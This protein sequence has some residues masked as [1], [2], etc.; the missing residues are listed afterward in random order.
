MKNALTALA[1][2]LLAAAPATAAKK[3]SAKEFMERYFVAVDSKKPEKIAELDAADIDFMTPMGTFKGVAGHLQLTSGFAT[4]FPNFKHTVSRCIEQA[5]T[6]ACEGSFAGDHTGPMMMPN[7]Q[8]IPATN[9]H[10]EFTW[11][12]IA[13]VKGGKI[14]SLHVYFDTMAMMQQLGLVPPAAVAKK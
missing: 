8:S 6:V 13:T 14:A 7:G 9:K 1:L 3:L 5:E 11:G 10:V 12:G 2:T 4:A